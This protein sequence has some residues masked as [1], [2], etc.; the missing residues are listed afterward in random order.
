MLI[1]S[2][3]DADDVFMFYALEKKL[4]K[5]RTPARI[6]RSDIQTLNKLAL[7]GRID[8]SSVSF[9]AYPHFSNRYSLLSCGS[10]FGYSYGP[11]IVS[12]RRLNGLDGMKVAVPG[13][14][15]TAFLLLN[16]F[17]NGFTPVEMRFDRIMNAVRSGSVDA[18]IVLHEGQLMYRR[19]GL[20]KYSSLGERWFEETSL[21][22]PL[23]A[24]AVKNRIAYEASL[25]IKLSIAYSMAFPDG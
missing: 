12:R 17:Y 4:V 10:S 6:F 13:K 19:L 9:A 16:I 18:G 22:L 7:R 15:T 25:A 1:G 20:R 24:V 11:I 23:G 21:P 8:A 3:S 14:N 5:T 2:S